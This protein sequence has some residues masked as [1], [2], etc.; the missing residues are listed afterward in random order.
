MAYINIII[1][2]QKLLVTV[3]YRVYQ[4]SSPDVT[5]PSCGFQRKMAY[6]IMKNMLKRGPLIGNLGIYC[7]WFI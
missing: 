6:V 7:T 3:T 5:E 4:K 1:H 2:A